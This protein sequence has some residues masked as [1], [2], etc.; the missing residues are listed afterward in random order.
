[1]VGCLRR[2][3]AGRL[4]RLQRLHM[5]SDAVQVVGHMDSSILCALRDSVLRITPHAIKSPL[6]DGAIKYSLSGRHLP[7]L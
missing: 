6:F 2:Y 1:M 3:E 4:T 7:L 5:L